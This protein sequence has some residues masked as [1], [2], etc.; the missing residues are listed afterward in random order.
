MTAQELLVESQKV[1]IPPLSLKDVCD[2]CQNEAYVRVV[3]NSGILNFC[4]HHFHENESE[5]L[6]RGYEIR[7]ERSRLLDRDYRIDVWN[8]SGNVKNR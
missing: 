3:T 4:G 1:E 6:K 2:R 5:F 7:D 8:R